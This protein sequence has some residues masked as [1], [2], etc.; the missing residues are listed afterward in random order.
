MNI[1]DLRSDTV[2]HPTPAMREAMAAAEVGDDVY[3]EDP[4]I[5]RLQKL[6][7]EKMGKAAGLFSAAALMS[8][9]RFFFHSHLAA[10]DVPV[11]AAVFFVTFLFWRTV[12]RKEWWWGLVLGLAWGLAEAVKLNATFI[13][14]GLFIWFLLFRRKWYVIYRFLLMGFT[15]VVTFFLVWPWL[16]HQ[17]WARVMEY[18]NFELHS[19]EHGQWYLGNYYLIPPWHFTFVML[20][21]VVPLTLMLLAFIGMARARRGKQDM[22]PAVPA[23]KY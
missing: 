3:G 23:T 13:P 8:M 16:Y 7:A 19:S 18:V 21:A 10:L 9:P 5:N 20:W 6:A 2:T 11:A 12:D 22:F 14:I 4:T 15:A 1:I 17:T